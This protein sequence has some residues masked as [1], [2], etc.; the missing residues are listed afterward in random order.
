VDAGMATG[1][2]L[3]LPAEFGPVHSLGPPAGPMSRTARACSIERHT[4]ATPPSSCTRR[5]NA[6][7]PCRAQS[8]RSALAGRPGRRCCCARAAPRRGHRPGDALLDLV[9]A[10]GGGH[11][12][13]CLASRRPAVGIGGFA[14]TFQALAVAARQ[15][16]RRQSARRLQRDSLAAVPQS[17]TVTA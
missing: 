12:S 10:G 2:G 1:Q 6:C 14:N 9:F 4:A 5:R 7:C 16:V 11:A 3:Q 8:A 15:P 17:S 13:C